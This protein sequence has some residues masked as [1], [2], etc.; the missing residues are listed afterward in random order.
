MVEDAN[1][2]LIK[3]RAS[4]NKNAMNIESGASRTSLL[5]LQKST[6]RDLLQGIR[7]DIP[8][9]RT[10]ADITV[11]Q[12]SN[13]SS[14]TDAHSCRSLRHSAE[15]F[16]RDPEGVS[17]ERRWQIAGDIANESR[18]YNA[19]PGSQVVAQRMSSGK[20]HFSPGDSFLKRLREM[21]QPQVSE[22]VPTKRGSII[23]GVVDRHIYAVVT[24]TSRQAAIA[25]RQCM[26]DG[27]GLGRWEEIGDLPIPPLADSSP[28]DICLCRACCRPVTLT[29]NDSQKRC[30]RNM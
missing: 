26:S 25:G 9:R 20:W 30:R 6:R 22:S 4:V 15:S 16:L 24:F 10:F 18:Q 14:G 13:S 29:I 11:G 17:T 19:P 23:G 1:Q 27:S 12:N 5:A 2:A 8:E 28:W 21:A 7:R 3:A